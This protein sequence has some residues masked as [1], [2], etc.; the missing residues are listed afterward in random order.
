MTCV[1]DFSGSVELVQEQKSPMDELQQEG[2]VTGT[3]GWG[4]RERSVCQAEVDPAAGEPDS[5]AEKK[6]LRSLP[7]ASKGLC[8]QPE[9][10]LRVVNK[11]CGCPERGAGTQKGSRGR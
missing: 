3:R 10:D 7:S 6:N 9:R 11:S 2:E 4:A 5:R 8:P 1:G